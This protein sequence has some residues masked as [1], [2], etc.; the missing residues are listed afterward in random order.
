MSDFE[1]RKDSGA[2]HASK[3]KSKE[4]SP[5]YWGE[6]CIDIKDMT[7]VT[8]TKEGFLVFHLSGWKKQSKAG[9]VYLSLL[10][11]RF[12]PN[13]QRYSS[14]EKKNDDMNDDLSDIPF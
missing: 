12:V 10:V 4:T 8:K 7:N 1:Q 14:S 3:S 5:D 2:L 6:I 9:N 11:D 13:Q